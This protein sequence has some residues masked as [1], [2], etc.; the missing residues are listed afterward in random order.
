ML[1]ALKENK[2]YLYCPECSEYLEG[3][4]GNL[5][6]CYCGWKQPKTYSDREITDNDCPFCR[7]A[8]MR[9]YIR[10]VRCLECNGSGYINSQD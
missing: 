3:G 5:Q 8:F 6:D 4:D 9:G 7:G 10:G 2:M 1:P